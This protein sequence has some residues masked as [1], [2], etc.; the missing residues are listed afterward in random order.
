LNLK[1]GMRGEQ[2][3]C[4]GKR[5]PVCGYRWVEGGGPKTAGE[6]GGGFP[7]RTDEGD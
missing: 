4:L 2:R 6:K 7:E 3:E 1:E 5:S